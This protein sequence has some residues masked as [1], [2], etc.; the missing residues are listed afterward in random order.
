[1]IYD[2]HELQYIAH[3]ALIA[4]RKSLQKH[5]HF[6]PIGLVFHDGGLS[7]AFEFSSRSSP[8]KR[9]SQEVFKRLVVDLNAEAAIVVTESWIKVGP[10]IPLDR[11]KSIADDPER[12][13]ALVIEAASPHARYLIIQTFAKDAS[14]TVLFDVPIDTN[15]TF[16]GWSEWLDGVWPESN[17]KWSV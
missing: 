1:M 14:G 3:K 12:T 15:N 5:G 7:Q 10:E 9:I 2:W 13:E 11:T 4:A 8:D 16:D 17:P 6:E